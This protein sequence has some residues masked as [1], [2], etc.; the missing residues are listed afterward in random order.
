MYRKRVLAPFHIPHPPN[1]FDERL[2]LH[3]TDRATDLDNHHIRVLALRQL[4]D[5]PGNRTHQMRHHLHRLPQK[6]RTQTFLVQQLVIDL[7]RGHI[8]KDR[9]ILVQ[10]ALVMPQVQIRFATVHRHEHLAMF[11]RRHRARVN[12]QIRVEFENSDPQPPILQHAPD[13]CTG[14]ALA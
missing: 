11:E 2:R 5:T 9:E 13:R 10:E 14:D 6:L 4:A 7:P 1:S 3:V 12:V 8:R